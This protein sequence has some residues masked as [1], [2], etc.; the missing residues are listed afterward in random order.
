MAPD[1]SRQAFLRGGLGMVAGVLLG[2]CGETPERSALADAPDWGALAE[3]IQGQLTLPSSA[4]YAGA[5]NLFNSR[6]DNSTPA[7]VV[8]VQSTGDVQQAVAFAA[9]NGIQVAARSGGHSYIG[10]SAA[11]GVMVIDLRQLPGDTAYDD[12]SGLATIPAAAELDSVQTTLAAQE[13]LIPSGS[14]PTVGVAGLTLGGGL[15]SD[16]RQWGLTCDALVSAS[17]VLPSGD[18]ITATP[19][20]HADLYW[21][22]RGGEY[23][24]AVISARICRGSTPF[25]GSTTPTD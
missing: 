10:A 17:V 18:A 6:Y 24:V 14:C 20:D 12:E 16:A 2:S 13:R 3:G 9:S 21:A 4:D 25:V 19:D 8:T 22:L 15:G 7:A 1:I 5:K 11:N 23:G